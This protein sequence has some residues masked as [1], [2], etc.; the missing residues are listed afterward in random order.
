MP[1]GRVTNG[2]NFVFAKKPVL[3]IKSL[4]FRSSA[5]VYPENLNTKGL[6][7]PNPEF[8]QTGLYLKERFK[9]WDR[10]RRQR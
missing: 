2:L 7:N 4:E 8:R 6:A 10:A 3:G 5:D 9:R 1:R